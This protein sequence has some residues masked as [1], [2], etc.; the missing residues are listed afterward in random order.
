MD[1]RIFSFL[2]LLGLILPQSIA[3]QTQGIDLALAEQYF[4]EAQA[5]CAKDNGAL[6]GISLAGPMMFVDRETRMIAANHS[7]SEGRLTK[8]GKIFI[9]KLP[10]EI[11]ISNTA[12]KW[13]GVKWTMVSYPLPVDKQVR[14]QLMLHELFHRVQEDLG[15]AAANPANNHLDSFTG[16]LW[17]QYEWRALQ[18]A[19]TAQGSERQ[20][21]IAD[22][23]MFRAY[24]RNLFPQAA[25]SENELEINEGLAEYTGVKLCG[26]SDAVSARFFAGELRRFESRPT[27]VRSFAY[28]SGPAYGLLLDAI[29]PHWRKAIKQLGDMGLILAKAHRVKLPV[30]FKQAAERRAKPYDCTSLLALESE[31]ESRREKR[32]AGYRAQ[33]IEGAVLS[34]PLTNEVQYSFNPN[35]VEVLDDANTVFPNLRISDAWGILNV[36]GGAVLTRLDGRVVKVTVAAPTNLPTTSL[37]GDGWT[38]ELKDGWQVVRGA[39]P[40]DFTLK[41]Q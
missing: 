19:L 33:F 23:L 4:D 6:W 10:D 30:N 29:H 27:F 34:I 13:A 7:D 40:G 17:L 16:R 21:A 11:N 14:A 39:R 28:A 24:R 8:R 5:I 38:L 12:L 2:F 41:R 1:K 36:T 35:N 32:V 22:A 25:R 37:Q 3:A 31:R 20:K 9:G 15:F 18:R 26:T